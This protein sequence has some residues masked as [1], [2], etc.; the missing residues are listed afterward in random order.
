MR[1]RPLA[2]VVPVATSCTLPVRYDKPAAPATW[3]PPLA[4]VERRIVYATDAG[5]STK[6]RAPA[7]A[8]VAPH[9][10]SV[11]RVLSVRSTTSSRQA[12]VMSLLGSSATVKRMR[13]ASVSATCDSSAKLTV[14][15]VF[16]FDG[17]SSVVQCAPASFD[18]STTSSSSCALPGRFANQRAYSSSRC[19]KPDARNTGDVS[20]VVPST[21]FVPALPPAAPVTQHVTPLP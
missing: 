15:H 7:P 19:E 14:C 6:R 8:F 9:A 11:G 17:D 13:I 4:C 16:A 18:T 2:S 10:P 21:S 20:T 1:A 12:S 5:P 3:T